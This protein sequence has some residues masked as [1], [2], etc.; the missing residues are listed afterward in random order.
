MKKPTKEKLSETK[1]ALSGTYSLKLRVLDFATDLT[2]SDLECELFC[3]QTNEVVAKWN[4]R[5]TEEIYVEN[6]RYSFDKPDSYN[7]NITY[8]IR[9]T[10]LP[11]NYRF[12]YG[13]SREMYGI[14]GFSPE[15][16]ENGTELDCIAYLENT[17]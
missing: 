10:N 14:C 1:P 11:E 5:D 17:K 6:L 13:K 3:L 12:Y 2:V 16:F 9:I 7:G 8:A 4:T 15:E